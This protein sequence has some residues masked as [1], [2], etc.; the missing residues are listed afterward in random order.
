MWLNVDFTI[1]IRTFARHFFFLWFFCHAP[2]MHRTQW[3]SLKSISFE[4]FEIDF[5]RLKYVGTFFGRIPDIEMIIKIIIMDVDVSDRNNRWANGE[6]NNICIWARWF[7]FRIRFFYTLF[8]C[9]VF[10]A[11]P[12]SVRGFV[13]RATSV[14]SGTVKLIV[15][16]LRLQHKRITLCLLQSVSESRHVVSLSQ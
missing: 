11:I 13:V 3:Y 5:H 9:V 10:M 6:R 16:S 4:P 12:Y 14:W 15:Q 2:A 1:I 8:R 7:C